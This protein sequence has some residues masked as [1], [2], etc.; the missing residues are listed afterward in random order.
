MAKLAILFGIVFLFLFRKIFF[1]AKDLLK[2]DL[3]YKPALTLQCA[4]YATMF[5]AFGTFA[6][7]ASIYT[8]ILLL[9]GE[10][11]L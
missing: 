7:C 1:Y 11:H 2:R 4:L 8:I 5:G 6:I 9:S 10:G 3:E